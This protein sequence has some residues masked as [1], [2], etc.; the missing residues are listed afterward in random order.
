MFKYVSCI[1][2]GCIDSFN[3]YFYN[4][5]KVNVGNIKFG[6]EDKYALKMTIF[7]H[8]KAPSI[9]E[10]VNGLADFNHD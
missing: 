9:N 6:L 1:V 5:D 10:K 2:V 8:L 4:I 7:N 3:T